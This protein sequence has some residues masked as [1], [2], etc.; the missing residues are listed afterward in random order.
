MLSVVIPAYN[1]A[2]RLPDTI[3]KIKE[4]LSEKNILAE[5]I[6]VDDG[7]TDN[8]LAMIPKDVKVICNVVNQGKGYSVRQ[9]V[10]AAKGETI[11]FTDA[12]LSTPIAEIEKLLPV[13]ASGYDIAIGSRAMKD[14]DVRVHQPFLR[15]SMGK[16]FNLL[17]RLIALGGIAD[18]QCGFKVFKQEAARKIFPRQKL[19]GFGFDVEVLFLGRKFG[20]KIKEVPVVWLDS[21]K[22]RVQVWKDPLLMF[23]D[24]IRLRCLHLF[25]T[26]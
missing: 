19:K 5:L 10:L 25:A 9:G 1:E 15:E 23:W 6:V 16:V 3:K 26:R 18:T 2:K 12:D 8:T 11:L 7:S 4:Y 14:S 22:S 17:V 21:P 20:Y 13:L 24:I